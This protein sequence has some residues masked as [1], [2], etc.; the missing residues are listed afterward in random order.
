MSP[1]ATGFEKALLAY[2]GQD[3]LA[4]ARLLEKLLIDVSVGSDSRHRSTPTA[5]IDLPFK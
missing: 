4:L 1:S 5:A 3:M 2:C